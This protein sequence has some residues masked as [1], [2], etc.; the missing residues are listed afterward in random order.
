MLCSWETVYEVIPDDQDTI[1]ATLKR[2]VRYSAPVPK[3]QETM[4]S[5]M[6]RPSTRAA[7]RN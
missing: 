6:T 2:L 4:S 3:D 5:A 1:E 7:S